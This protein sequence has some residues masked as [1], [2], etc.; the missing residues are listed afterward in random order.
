LQDI[1][2]VTKRGFLIIF[3]WGAPIRWMG[4]I[5]LWFYSPKARKNV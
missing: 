5:F 1:K 2:S 4:A 3:F